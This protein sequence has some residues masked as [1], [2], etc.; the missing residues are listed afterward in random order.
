MGSLRSIWE[1]LR[2]NLWFVPTLMVVGAIVVAVVLI[3]LDP[4]SSRARLTENW[5]R[6]FGA[7]AQGARGLLAAI[8][9]SMITVAGVT[10]SIT[11]VALALA[12]S[13]YTSRILA[14]F[15]RDRANQSVLGVY[16][17]V[18]AYCLVVLRTIRGGDEGVFVPALAVLG[19]VLLAFVAIGFLIFFI[20][21][22]AESIQATSVIETTAKETLLAVDRLFPAGLG[23]A[24]ETPTGDATQL[25]SER[26]RDWT[27]VRASRSGYIQAVDAEALFSVARD[28]DL[29]VRMESSVGDFVVESC[30]LAAVSPR[31]SGDEVARRVNMAFSVGRHRTVYQD[32]GY[33]IRQIVDVALKALSP[34]INDTTTAINCIDFLGAILVRL[35]GRRIEPTH[36]S[37][38]DRLRVIARGPTFPDLLGESF[39]QIRQNAAGNVAVLTRLLQVLAILAARLVDPRRRDAV[40]RQGDLVVRHAERTVPESL[41]LVTIHAAHHRVSSLP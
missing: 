17:G 39:D 8:A 27:I 40:S 16:V 28:L 31:P 7:G 38:G 6:L 37:D 32:A 41:D 5:P 1:K 15:M 24:T 26:A 3:E 18:F 9:S 35:A 10:F 29:I 22:I 4:I 20:H 33:G 11:V 14:N 34:G 25:E 12:S 21:H 2:E 36:R 19:A 13:Q 30:P 23:E